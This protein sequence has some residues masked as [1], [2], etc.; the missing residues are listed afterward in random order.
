M[1]E[2]ASAIGLLGVGDKEGNWTVE[3]DDLTQTDAGALKVI[4]PSGAS[5][6]F[7][8]A[9]DRA[10]VQLEINGIVRPDDTDAIVI[11]ST[12][13]VPMMV[14][15]PRAAPG[16]TGRIGLRHIGMAELLRDAATANDLSRRFREEACI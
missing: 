13:P 9:N 15:T 5:R 11:H 12:S 16:R 3:A 10:G 7:F 1:R 8:A 14:R 2:M 6:V 4:T